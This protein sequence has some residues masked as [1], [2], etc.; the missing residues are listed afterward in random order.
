MEI[1]L[2]CSCFAKDINKDV[3]IKPWNVCKRQGLF[4]SCHEAFVKSA[5]TNLSANC[6]LSNLHLLQAHSEFFCFSIQNYYYYFVSAVAKVLGRS[7]IKKSVV[8]EKHITLGYTFTTVFGFCEPFAEKYHNWLCS[9]FCL[10]FVLFGSVYLFPS[11][12]LLYECNT[13]L[14]LCVFVSVL[15]SLHSQRV[16]KAQRRVNLHSRIL[17]KI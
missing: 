10:F 5:H 6:R 2:V 11:H 14:L 7:E 16:F 4:S 3:S 8:K 17:G 9:K 1:V 12:R 13:H 15:L